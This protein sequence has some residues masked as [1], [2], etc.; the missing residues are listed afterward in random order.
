MMG[1]FLLYRVFINATNE[2]A[3]I[4][5]N[6]EHQSPSIMYFSLMILAILL[7]F[8]L[9]TYFWQTVNL[10]TITEHEIRIYNGK[11]NRTFLLEDVKTSKIITLMGRPV[12]KIIMKDGS[13]HTIEHDKVD[14][15]F[16]NIFNSTKQAEQSKMWQK[17]NPNT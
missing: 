16:S 9:T 17:L 13:K 7:L 6:G 5:V 3:I 8:G 12:I 15:D 10:A 14:P 2:N 4:I 1:S 11:R